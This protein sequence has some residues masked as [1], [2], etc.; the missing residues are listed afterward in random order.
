MPLRISGQD[1]AIR[2]GYH[3]AA[4]VRSWTVTRE[5]GGSY[6]L[7]AAIVSSDAY[8]LSQRPL[9]FVAPHAKGAWRWPIEALQMTG[10]SLTATLGPKE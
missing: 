5:D 2:W 10:A 7:A 1:A 3:A 6:V 4:V 8:R 9:V